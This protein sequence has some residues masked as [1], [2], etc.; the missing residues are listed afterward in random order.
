MDDE[1]ERLQ[2]EFSSVCRKRHKVRLQQLKHLKAGGYRS[3]KLHQ[4]ERELLAQQMQLR[5][6]MV[7]LGVPIPMPWVD[8]R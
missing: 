6:T 2:R 1:H 4:R 5:A 3:T 8:H 7:G